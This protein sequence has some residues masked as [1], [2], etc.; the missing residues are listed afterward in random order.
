MG[1]FNLSVAIMK[2]TGHKNETEFLKNIRLNEEE[3]ALDLR[4]N[5]FF[6]ISN[7]PKKDGESEF[8]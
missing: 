2:I 6:K 7:F 5:S 3:N 1:C 8:F 4:E